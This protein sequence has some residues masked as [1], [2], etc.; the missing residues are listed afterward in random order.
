MRGPRRFIVP[1]LLLVLGLLGAEAS[2]HPPTPIDRSGRE[3]GGGLHRWMHRSKAPLV[4]GRV[5][6]IRAACPGNP[7]L[8]G[9]VFPRR[10]RRIYMGTRLRNPRRLLYHELAHVFDLRVLNN[11]ERRG[12]KRIMGI[13][14][15]GWFRGALPPAEWFAEGYANCAYRRTIRRAGRPTA[16]GYRAST[17]QHRRVCLLIARA[18]APRGRP[19]QKPANP[20]PVIETKPPPPSPPPPAEGPSCNPVEQLLT[21]CAPRGPLSSPLP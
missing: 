12:F 5:Q 11:A 19:P 20:P 9:C 16:Y 3:F 2:A 13:R 17:R 6:I 15:G 7:Q 8:D 4:K 14:R 10:P 1:L 18:A 21:G